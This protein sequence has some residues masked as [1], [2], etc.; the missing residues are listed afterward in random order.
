MREAEWLLSLDRQLTPACI[1]E[2]GFE[3]KNRHSALME[4]V[5]IYLVKIYPMLKVCFCLSFRFVSIKLQH[6]RKGGANLG[7]YQPNSR[8][9]PSALLP[10]DARI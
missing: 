6:S 9:K 7:L 10:S 3:S 2:R 8:A 4:F 5:N 1:D